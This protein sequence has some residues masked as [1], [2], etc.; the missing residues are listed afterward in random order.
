LSR[1]TWGGGAIYA[2]L[3][4]G[5]DDA[6]IPAVLHAWQIGTVLGGGTLLMLDVFAA[7]VPS[8]ALPRWLAWSALVLGIAEFTR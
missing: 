5:A 6:V 3:G 4:I 7:G 8:R 2:L 1:P